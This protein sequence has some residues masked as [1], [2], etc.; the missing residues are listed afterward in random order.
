MKLYILAIVTAGLLSGCDPQPKPPGAPK[1]ETSPVAA[2]APA[3]QQRGN[4]ITVQMN[5]VS[6]DGVGDSAGSI[7]I[8]EMPGGLVFTPAL[9]G[10]AQGEHGFHLHEN[11]S[12]EPAMKEGK[13]QAA[14]GAGSHFDPANTNRHA[15]PDGNGHP[16]DL[17]RLRITDNALQQDVVAKQLSLDDVKNRALVV[18]EGA[19]DY[20]TDPAGD[21][22]APIACGVVQ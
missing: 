17:P 5:K 19:D 15:G 21:S 4:S 11:P 10:L 1:G 3:A 7:T 12:C 13:P 18:H 8:V 20:S 16:G 2:P 6:A 22:G 14:A 9:Q